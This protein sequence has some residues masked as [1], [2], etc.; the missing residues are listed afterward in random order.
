MRNCRQSTPFFYALCAA[1][2]TNVPLDA[3]RCQAPRH[4]E[5]ESDQQRAGHKVHEHGDQRRRLEDAAIDASVCEYPLERIGQ[6]IA[7]VVDEVDKAVVRVSAG[8]Q[9]TEPKAEYYLDDGQSNGDPRGEHADP[10]AGD[11]PRTR[12]RSGYLFLGVYLVPS[13]MG[14]LY[15]LT[16]TDCRR[17]T[18]TFLLDCLGPLAERHDPSHSFAKFSGYSHGFALPACGAP[19]E[20]AW[21]PIKCRDGRRGE[22]ADKLRPPD[23]FLAVKI[24]ATPCACFEYHLRDL[25]G[26]FS[27]GMSLGCS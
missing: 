22:G 5:D 1:E 23:V 2:K 20:V 11:A 8:E 7:D 13:V 6:W 21:Q 26:P 9:K 25:L 27:C 12:R 14:W 10:A 16:L 17:M 4:R 24:A 3:R 19:R 15:V 18:A